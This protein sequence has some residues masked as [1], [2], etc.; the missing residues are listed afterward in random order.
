MLRS[1]ASAIHTYS[2]SK[3]GMMNEIRSRYMYCTGAGTVQWQLQVD[4][5][6]IQEDS[7]LQQQRQGV[8]SV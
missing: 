7:S 3:H 5:P 2:P 1:A 6:R 8:L 4:S